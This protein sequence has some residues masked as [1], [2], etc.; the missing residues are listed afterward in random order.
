M[1]KPQ[2]IFDTGS[3][4]LWVP[5]SKCS[6]FSIPCYLHRWAVFAAA[7]AAAVAAAAA[8]CASACT[9]LLPLMWQRHS[10]C[11]CLPRLKASQKLLPPTCCPFA[12]CAAPRSSAPAT[13]GR[14]LLTSSLGSPSA[15][16]LLNQP[17]Q[18]AQPN[19]AAFAASTTP[20]SRARTA[21]TAATLRSS[22]APDGCR[23][24][25]PRWVFFTHCQR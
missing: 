10:S 5:S 18:P 6:Y 25:C 4:N 17:S 13:Q 21:R 22:T 1:Q 20:R 16:N 15:S 24:S 14:P 19:H 12:A 11:F 7:A 9:L 2:V 8:A 23:A 3:S